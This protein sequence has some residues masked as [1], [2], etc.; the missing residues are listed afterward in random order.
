MLGK[1]GIKQLTI[2]VGAR[3]ADIVFTVEIGRSQLLLAGKRWLCG[4]TQTSLSVNSGVRSVPAGVC[5]V[6]V[7]PRS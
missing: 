1:Q 3:Q 6:S 4:S 2:A 7:R 5:R